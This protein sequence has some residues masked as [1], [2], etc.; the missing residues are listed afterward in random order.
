MQGGCRG[1]ELL[2]NEQP[3]L[4]FPFQRVY[5]VNGRFDVY[6]ITELAGLPV[7]DYQLEHRTFEPFF[8]DG[9]VGCADGLEKI[10]AR[11]FE[12]DGVGSVVH[13]PHGVGF[14]VAD[15]DMARVT[16]TFY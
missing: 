9:S 14:G 8:F 2:A 12:P 1:A 10:D 3:V 13:D 4:E 16:Q 11:L 5:L 6:G 15:L 7:T